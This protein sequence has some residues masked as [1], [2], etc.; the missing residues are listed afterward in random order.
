M[1][2]RLLAT[3][4]ALGVSIG[5]AHTEPVPRVTGSPITTPARSLPRIT[6]RVYDSTQVDARARRDAVKR[7]RQVLVSAGL[8]SEFHD[9]S[10]GT[11]ASAQVCQTPPGQGE[12]II[13]MV[14]SKDG[15]AT[16]TH[17]VLGFATIDAATRRGT[18][19]TVFTDRVLTLATLAHVPIETL[20][21]RTMA[22]EI[23]HLLLGT[24]EHGAMGLM[25]EVWTLDEL[26]NGKK[27][28]W[29]FTAAEVER[30]HGPA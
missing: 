20:L 10:P 1:R 27:E 7:T 5:V 16:A 13:R 24:N 25:R 26:A 22:H 4:V 2:T 29:F 21:G 30:F 3:V 9:C 23:G 17:H 28:H 8:R 12:L 14:R 19:A 11:S 15:P 18:M 6:V